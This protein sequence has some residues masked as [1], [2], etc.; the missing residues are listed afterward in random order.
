[1]GKKIE[2][3]NSKTY[4]FNRTINIRP[5]SIDAFGISTALGLVALGN[6]I[7]PYD[8]YLYSYKTAELIAEL[9]GHTDGFY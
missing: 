9:K 2:V 6:Y 7:K 8:I 3:Y 1:M 4:K 5:G